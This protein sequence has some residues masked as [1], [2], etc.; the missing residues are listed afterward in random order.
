VAARL[1][2]LRVA[3]AQPAEE[4]AAGQAPG[5]GRPGLAPHLTPEVYEQATRDEDRGGA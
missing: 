3:P 2:A 4:G 5:P 1:R